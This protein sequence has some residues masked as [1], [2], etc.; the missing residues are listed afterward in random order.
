MTRGTSLDYLLVGVSV[1][2]SLLTLL[3][4]I[5]VWIR[6]FLRSV[7]D[8]EYPDPVL[9]S[10]T[11]DGKRPRTS[12]PASRDE[13]STFAGRDAVVLMPSFMVG[14]TTAL[15]VVGVALTV[16]AGPLFDLADNASQNLINPDRYIDAVFAP[17]GQGGVSE[18]AQ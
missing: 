11:R 7:D 4:L 10:R 13:S 3:A 1:F 2:V 16:F 15:V 18:E 6:V 12:G 8:A 5:R 17:V 14:A 9:R